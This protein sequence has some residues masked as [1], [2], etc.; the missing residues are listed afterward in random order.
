VS[1]LWDR[2]FSSVQRTSP[3]APATPAAPAVPE[4][5]A[6]ARFTQTIT[7]G[8]DSEQ[9]GNTQNVFLD[10][11]DRV[12][13]LDL[14]V[15]EPTVPA[16]GAAPRRLAPGESLRAGREYLVRVSASTNQ[17]TG[18]LPPGGISLQ[19]RE[20]RTAGGLELSLEIQRAATATERVGSVSDQGALLPSKPARA[21]QHDFRLL[22]RDDAPESATLVLIYMEAGSA[23]NP[24]AA[25]LLDIQIEGGRETVPETIARVL[26][27]PVN[28][29][30]PERT[31]ILH[32][33]AADAGRLQ[34]LR[35]PRDLTNRANPVAIVD[36]PDLAF[37]PA[38]DATEFLED[39]RR[40]TRRVAADNPGNIIGWL[41]TVVDA[42]GD[43]CCVVIVDEADS[44]I[45]WEMLDLDQR[46]YLGTA[47]RVVRWTEAQYR[48]QVL[49]L[50]LG[51]AV[52]SGR[53]AAYVQATAGASAVQPSPSL[54]QLAARLWDSPD[55]LVED[56]VT[57]VSPVGLVYVS[58]RGLLANGDEG[59]QVLAGMH[60]PGPATDATDVQF[61]DAAGLAPRPV[62]FVNAPY[63]ARVPW[64]GARRCGVAHAA[65]TQV[66]AGY[67]GT[68]GP[69]DRKFAEEI[70]EELLREAQSDEGVQPAELL[71]RL[72]TRA[73]VRLVDASLD[74]TQRR[75]EF[76]ETFLYVYYGNPWAR[77]RLIA[78]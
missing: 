53:L 44:R 64:R 25:S 65:L 20:V 5:A 23:N 68:V 2:V 7:A 22:V 34:L 47:A 10:L 52:H 14:Q 48:D 59:P 41:R 1:P 12:F 26:H 17:P 3:A 56:L 54:H 28:A 9:R 63:S 78:E 42:Y 73:A 13:Y 69:V 29:A 75:R 36:S 40:G 19:Q 39:V 77:I 62:F 45:S 51:E 15:L 37:D 30:L 74:R 71:R 49:G 55:E 24:R 76:T 67:I 33:H 72:R 60:I 8:A 38:T 50:E 70:A 46:R 58:S 11:V 31:A 27:L 57:G 43:D 21:W 6:D 35:V 4:R 32:I 16:A 61:D 18:G 66:A